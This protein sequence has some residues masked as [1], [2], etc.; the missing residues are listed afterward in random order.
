MMT[1]VVQRTFL[2]AVFCA[3]TLA[4]VGNAQVPQADKLSIAARVRTF[5]DARN[6]HD[7]TTVAALYSVDGEYISTEGNSVRGRAELAKLW[8]SVTGQV[9]RTVE[10][11]EFA[12][13][14]IALV[15][16]NMLYPDIGE[17]HETFVFV[18]AGARW[19][20][21]VHQTVD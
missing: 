10:S 12:G 14:N 19:E 9:R 18:K 6:A 8:S 15:R 17:H 1:K 20:I 16:V 7:G 11:V 3:A 13:P 4:V 2:I 21:R 5:A